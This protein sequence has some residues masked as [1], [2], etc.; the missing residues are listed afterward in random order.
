MIMDCC[1][2]KSGVIESFISSVG[3]GYLARSNKGRQVARPERCG[4]SRGLI[5]HASF[6]A[7][8]NFNKPSVW[9][10]ADFIL[11]GLNG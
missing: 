5:A 1:I 10:I 6:H 8:P 11:T 3:S 7:L 4:M 2:V 9:A